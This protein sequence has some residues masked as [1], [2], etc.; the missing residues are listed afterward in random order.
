MRDI[1]R[2]PSDGVQETPPARTPAAAGASENVPAGTPAVTGA[3]GNVPAG[4]PVAIPD[5]ARGVGTLVVLSGAGISTDSGIQDFRG[6]SG[7]WTLNPDAPRKHT[8]QAFLADPE[9]RGRYWRS[10]YEHPIWG[11]EPNPGHLAVASLTGSGVDTTVVTQNTDGLHQRAG[12]PADRVIELHGTMHE[13]M[14]VACGHRFPTVDA[15]ARIEAGEAAPGCPQCGGITKTAS[16]MFGQTMSPEVFARAE[17]AVTTCDLLLAVGTTLTIEPAGSLCAKAVHA[18]AALVIVNW[19]PTPY[20]GIATDIIR[21][22]LS[23]G[24]PRVARWLRAATTPSGTGPVPGGPG[25]RE[26]AR[27]WRAA[28]EY[29]LGLSGEVVAG[30]VTTA[31]LCGA[32]DEEQA[33]AS[34]EHISALRDPATRTRVAR[35]LRE[36]YPPSGPPP[37]WDDSLPGPVTEELSPSPYWDDS[38]PDPV[39]EELVAA[40]ATPRFL[41]RMFMGTTEEQERRALTVLARAA[42]TR[43]GSRARL[44]ELLS[45]LPGLSPT[46]VGVALSGGHPAPLAEALTSLARNAALPAELL[47]SVPPGTTVLGEF[48]VLLA[49]DLVGAYERRLERYPESAPRGLA[50][51]LVELAGRLADLG[52]AEEALAAARRAVEVA[53]GLA[54]PQDLPARAAAA[55]RRATDLARQGSG[56]LPET[57]A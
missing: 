48:P 10:R 9:L 55:V 28:E 3:P 4:T 47:D 7:Y 54:E 1:S 44:T 42:A 15:L 41:L 43:P 18:G 26:V 19:D 5:W 40:V 50:K 36:A 11:A 30:A 13:V 12:T 56:D 31:V 33:L 37:Y 45:V 52:R 21:D 34:L 14:C 6:P 35:W 22:P 23:E 39:A 24:L 38:L 25:G 27:L 2:T 17:R 8:Y 29:G 49:A 20:D 57:G 46:A 16:T 51:M 53:E 32:A